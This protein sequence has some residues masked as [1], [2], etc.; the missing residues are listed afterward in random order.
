MIRKKFACFGTKMVGFVKYGSKERLIV[1]MGLLLAAISVALQ[2]LARNVSGFGQWYAVTVYP[3][4]VGSLGRF[5][6]LFP[7]SVSEILLYSLL[8]F[9]LLYGIHNRGQVKK[10]ACRTFFLIS[11]LFFVYTVNCG[12]NYYRLPFSMLSGLQVKSRPKEELLALCEYLTEQVNQAERELTVQGGLNPAQGTGGPLTSAEYAG[13]AVKAMDSLGQK[14]PALSGY[15]PRPKSLMVPRVLSVQQLAGIYSPFSI[16]A[17][18]NGEMTPYNIP[19]TACHELSHLRGFMREDEANFIGFLA[20]T[21]SEHL[22]FRYSGYALGWI[23]A[24]NALAA[25]D[26][27]AYIECYYRLD[28]GVKKDFEDNTVFW[29]RFDTKVAEA[30]DKLNDAYLKA[31]SQVEGTKSYGRVVDL[32]LAWY[33][34]EGR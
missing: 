23:Y 21:E 24:G 6:G 25:V 20:C 27:E 14:Y 9:C 1:L 10:L 28:E 4:L 5:F 7:F 19:H 31:N 16:E 22:Y 33:E 26:R 30:A 11:C 29:G 32:M 17:N 3:L 15:Y 34:K 18:Y 12:V 2:F 13:E 8:V